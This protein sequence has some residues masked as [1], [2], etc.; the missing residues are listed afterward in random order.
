VEIDGYV[1]RPAE[2]ALE[3]IDP[4]AAERAKA[5]RRRKREGIVPSVSQ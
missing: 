4:E 1:A 5:E 3:R 2:A